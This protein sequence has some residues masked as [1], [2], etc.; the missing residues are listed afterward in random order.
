MPTEMSAEECAEEIERFTAEFVDNTVNPINYSSKTI[1]SM[2][3]AASVLRKVAEGKLRETVHCGECAHYIN[4]AYTDR[5]GNQ[6]ETNYF[7]DL[8]GRQ[9]EMG[10]DEYCS[11]GRRKDGAEH[12]R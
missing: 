2:Q 10:P 6:R 3:Y 8:Y 12:D 9:A 1:T 5:L 4:T 7:C 11:R